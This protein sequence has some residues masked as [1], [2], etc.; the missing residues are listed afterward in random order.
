MSNHPINP[1][2]WSEPLGYSQ[3]MLVKHPRETLYVAGQG[4]IDEDGNIV[5]VGDVVAQTQ[6]AMDNVETVLR[7]AGMTLADVVNWDVHATD[8]QNYFM[9]GAHEQAA[10]RFAKAGVLPAGG[11]AAESPALA[12]PEMLVEITVTAAR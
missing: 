6:R 2:P 7:A 4:S 1:W 12:L 3:G 5:H 8:L 9:S 10:K 11:I